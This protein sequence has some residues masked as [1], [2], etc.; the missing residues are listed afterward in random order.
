MKLE[1]VRSVE[2]EKKQ[3]RDHAC[4]E[5]TVLSGL[6]GREVVTT[7]YVTSKGDMDITISEVQA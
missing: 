3:I 5:I 7:V 1:H 6:P 4:V 2:I